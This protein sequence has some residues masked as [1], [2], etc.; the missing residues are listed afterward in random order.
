MGINKL[1]MLLL[2]SLQLL[3]FSVCLA[4]PAIQKALERIEPALFLVISGDGVTGSGFLYGDKKTII[5]NKHVLESTQLYETVQL[6]P[7]VTDSFGFKDLGKSFSGVL[8]FKHPDLDIAIISLDTILLS[9]P[10][11]SIELS[12]QKFLPRGTEILVHGFPS[13]LSPMVSSGL[14][15]GHYQ[16]SFTKNFYYL[17]DASLASGSSG[18]P[19]TN[20]DGNL[21][22]I[23]TAVHATGDGLGFNWGYIIP[24]HIM[25]REISIKHQSDLIL[26]IDKLAKKVSRETIYVT[27][28]DKIRTAYEEISRNSGS[29]EAL[30]KNTMEFLGKIENLSSVYSV[31]NAKNFLPA[32]SDVTEMYFERF[33]ILT[34]MNQ[35]QIDDELS[36][37]IFDANQAFLNWSSAAFDA[38]DVAEESDEKMFLEFFIDHFTSLVDQSV[39]VLRVNC[40]KFSEID[41]KVTLPPKTSPFLM[42]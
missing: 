25:E 40:T 22:G 30:A 24:V 29:Q 9:E 1:Q 4:D 21:V 8:T 15:S 17:T 14:I 16:D 41:F 23:A 38:L 11:E 42:R 18:G 20:M 7:I 3:L 32:V 39:E 33:F 5:T 19:V 36:E 6:K 27:R 2:L 37:L 26:D 13:A 10:I 34:L 35:L 28:L 31:S 12:G